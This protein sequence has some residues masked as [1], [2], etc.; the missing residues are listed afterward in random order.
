MTSFI[1]PVR[2]HIEDT[3][4][5]G[6]VY[7]ANYL[8]YFERARSEWIEHLGMGIDWQRACQIYFP[9]RSAHVDYL[10]PALLHEKLEVVSEI[11]SMKT[12]SFICSQY[13]RRTGLD[14]TI[15]CRAEIKIACT[16]QQMRPRAL[17][18]LA[19]KFLSELVR[20]I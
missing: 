1:F 13:L 2:V 6:V 17:P 8:N 19:K 5:A 14:D 15:L 11:K 18:E 7:H 16:D 3:D 20:E 12:A 4:F 10:R 9:V